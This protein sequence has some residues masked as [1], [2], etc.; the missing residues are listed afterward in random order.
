MHVC[1]PK[2]HHSRLTQQTYQI[3]HI[4][5]LH[6]FLYSPRT[7]PAMLMATATDTVAMAHPPQM[8]TNPRTTKSLKLKPQKPKP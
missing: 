1:A 4:L 8:W 5:F 2:L 7:H 6:S 3:V